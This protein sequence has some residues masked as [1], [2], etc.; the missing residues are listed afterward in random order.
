M[1]NA[2]DRMFS[3]VDSKLKR[4]MKSNKD[5]SD[6]C[7]TFMISAMDPGAAHFWKKQLRKAV[8]SS[9]KLEMQLVRSSLN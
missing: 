9:L 6:S 3:R 1:I 2:S 8:P 7:L 5:S 4:A